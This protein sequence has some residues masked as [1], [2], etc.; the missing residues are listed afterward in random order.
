[1]KLCTCALILAMAAQAGAATKVKSVLRLY[2]HNQTAEPVAAAM[3][4]ALDVLT[5][6]RG[7]E[8]RA[9]FFHPRSG[10]Q[11][12]TLTGEPG[13]V[14]A[15]R[16]AIASQLGGDVK[17]EA[18]RQRPVHEFRALKRVGE[19][20][21]DMTP[22]WGTWALAYLIGHS[23]GIGP[24]L[25]AASTAIGFPLTLIALGQQHSSNP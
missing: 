21:L 8:P 12:L 11:T 23:A 5:Q 20:L 14:A 3:T 9:G 15:A 6:H 25:A 24:Q 22:L 17:I 2:N 4:Q 7:V 16:K 19:R 18:V 13:A 1:M 10:R